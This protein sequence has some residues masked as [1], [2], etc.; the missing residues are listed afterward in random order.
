MN[1]TTEDAIELAN[2]IAR[3]LDDGG[4]DLVYAELVDTDPQLLALT[5]TL[6]TLS[7]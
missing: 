2:C 4:P 1:Y 6:S 7:R 3:W 5:L